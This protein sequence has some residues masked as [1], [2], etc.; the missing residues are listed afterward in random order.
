LVPA[1]SAGFETVSRGG[2]PR[3]R[4]DEFKYDVLLNGELKPANTTAFQYALNVW[5]KDDA[6]LI[7]T[8]LE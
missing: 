8:D 1:G 7:I 4:Y 3:Y 2:E 6:E 5:L